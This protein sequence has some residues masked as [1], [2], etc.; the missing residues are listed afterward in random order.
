MPHPTDAPISENADVTGPSFDDRLARRERLDAA[1]LR[2]LGERRVLRSIRTTKPSAL[3]D[4]LEQVVTMASTTLWELTGTASF[5]DETDDMFAFCAFL[6]REIELTEGLDLDAATECARMQALTDGPL[7]NLLPRGSELW[8]DGGH[9]PGAGEMI[10]Q[11]LADLEERAPKPLYLVVGMMGQKDA[12]G[13]LSPFRGLARAVLTVPVPAAHEPPHAPAALADAARGLGHVAEAQAGV[14]AALERVRVLAKGPV[15][16]L[17]CGSLYLAGH[18]LALQA[19]T[20]QQ[21]N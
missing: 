20:A 16:V 17:I 4:S 14:E 11:T 15:R 9:N 12:A 1:I 8:L 19:G 3:W 5:M 2:S 21:P 18:V 6:A 7:P 13:F 10:A